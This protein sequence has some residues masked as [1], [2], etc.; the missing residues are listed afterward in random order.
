[1]RI[2][3]AV[4]YL[5]YLGYLGDPARLGFIMLFVLRI[6]G[7]QGATCRDPRSRFYIVPMSSVA[8]K[9]SAKQY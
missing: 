4:G 6:V 8:R 9:R 1:M 2:V 7:G 3:V 5:G